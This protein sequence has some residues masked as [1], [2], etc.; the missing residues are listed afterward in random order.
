MTK[1]PIEIECMTIAELRTEMLGYL[2][3]QPIQ[4]WSRIEMGCGYVRH[5]TF[6]A[7]STVVYDGDELTALQALVTANRRCKKRRSD[8]ARK[9]AAT[10]ARRKE[11]R[12][13]EIASYWQETGRL[14]GPL[15]ACSL[16]GRKL[17]EPESIKRGIGP[18][19]WEGVLKHLQ[20]SIEGKD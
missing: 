2:N 1:Q 16:C 17:T 10:R 3:G 12:L 19:C 9:A 4:R 11:L 15:P 13:A 8:G 7:D 6:N 5:V 18:E 20:A 14:P